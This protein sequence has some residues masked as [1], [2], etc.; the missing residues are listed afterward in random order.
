MRMCDC[1]G[2]PLVNKDAREQHPVP[3]PARPSHCFIWQRVELDAPA[4]CDEYSFT[5]ASVFENLNM[6]SVFCKHD[7]PAQITHTHNKMR[8]YLDRCVSTTAFNRYCCRNYR[9]S[10]QSLFIMLDLNSG[11]LPGGSLISLNP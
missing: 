8:R 9:L 2:E 1:C 11:T 4:K 10:A 6:L 7:T 5:R 3:S